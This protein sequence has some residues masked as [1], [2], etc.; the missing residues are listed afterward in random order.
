MRLLVPLVSTTLAGQAP[1]QE[2]VRRRGLFDPRNAVLIALALALGVGGGRKL[3]LGWRGRRAVQRLSEPDLR[4]EDVLAVAGFGRSGLLDLFRLLTTAD[5]PAIRR[6]AGQA[7]ATLWERDDLIAEEEKAVVSRG[8]EVVWHARRRYPRALAVPI[9]IAVDF[10]LPFLGPPGPGI[11]AEQLE[12]S[13]RVLGTQRASLETYSPW[14][15]GAGRFRFELEPADFPGNGPHKLVLQARVRP[16]GLTSTWDLDLPHIPFQFD[17]DPLLQVQSLLT[18]PDETRAE[19]FSRAV[20]LAPPQTDLDEPRH[21]A[22]SDSLVLRDPPDLVVRTPLPC[23]LAHDLS[24]E[25]EGIA[26]RYPAGQV[27]LSGQGPSASEPSTEHRVPLI[28]NAATGPSP[29]EGPGELRVRAQLQANPHR[30]WA[31]PAIRSIW[32]GAIVTDWMTVRVIRR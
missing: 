29:I 18:L 32:P 12:W 9:P 2:A 4:P 6:A 31:D 15:P 7:L 20:C 23:D 22:V 26:G 28:W 19:A 30:G 17:F 5:K 13:Y 27:L 24:L 1:R 14:T 21:L 8:Y 25:F 3:W 10:G 11:T 16:R